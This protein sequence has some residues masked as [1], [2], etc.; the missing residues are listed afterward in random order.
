MGVARTASYRREQSFF[1]SNST[2]PFE[3]LSSHGEGVLFRAIHLIAFGQCSRPNRVVEV[4]FV[5][6]AWKLGARRKPRTRVELGCYD[7]VTRYDLRRFASEW[8]WGVRD[9]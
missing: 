9:E 5:R 4:E 6:V 7:L 8:K 2:G 3:C 1:S